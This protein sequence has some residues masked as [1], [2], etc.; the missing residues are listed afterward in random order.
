MELSDRACAVKQIV[1]RN[2]PW[3]AEK[4]LTHLGINWCLN[5]CWNAEDKE[6][7]RHDLEALQV[8]SFS[9]SALANLR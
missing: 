2:V 3:K 4:P 7:P 5:S 6:E 9:A 8:T 1:I